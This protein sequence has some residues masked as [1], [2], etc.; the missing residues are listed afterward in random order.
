M[1]VGKQFILL[2]SIFLL[3]LHKQRII[4]S[5]IYKSSYFHRSL[6]VKKLIDIGFANTP[7]RITLASYIKFMQLPTV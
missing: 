3:Q 6:N 4:S 7:K 2:V 1:M 5:I